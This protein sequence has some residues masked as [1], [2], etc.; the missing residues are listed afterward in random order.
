MVKKNI[1]MIAG[2]F[3]ER[4]GKY[5]LGLNQDWATELDCALRTVMD[6]KDKYKDKVSVDLIA[7]D[8]FYKNSHC[9]SQIRICRYVHEVIDRVNTLTYENKYDLILDFSVMP[10]FS[11]KGFKLDG[12]DNKCM[13]DTFT[14]DY[15][16]TVIGL[17]NQ[18]YLFSAVSYPVKKVRFDNGLRKYDSNYDVV[19]TNEIMSFDVNPEAEEFY[20][21]KNETFVDIST[22]DLLEDVLGLF[23]R[24]TKC[25]EEPFDIPCVEF[26]SDCKN[27]DNVTHS[28]KTGN[29]TAISDNSLGDRYIKAVLDQNDSND[30]YSR[31]VIAFTDKIDE[32]D[33][34]LH[35]MHI[36]TGRREILRTKNKASFMLGVPSKIVSNEEEILDFTSGELNIVQSLKSLWN[37]NGTKRISESTLY[38]FDNTALDSKETLEAVYDG[39][40][41]FKITT[42]RLAVGAMTLDV[43]CDENSTPSE[44]EFSVEV[45]EQ[46]YHVIE[47]IL[48][49]FSDITVVAKQ[50]QLAD[51]LIEKYGFERREDGAA[52]REMA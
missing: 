26:K 8:K 52:T 28:I 42:G 3:K 41:E 14:S 18:P 32:L 40:N 17:G 38:S 48:K 35:N 11:I 4:F 12:S 16:N 15:S 51:F 27:Y 13:G 19:V 21:T 7:D 10:K 23:D 9:D 2:V 20:I 24:K 31:Y 6:I 37:L 46:G 43:V 34:L 44:V 30:E 39:N 1:L 33:P 47:A 45:H 36:K 5:N 25:I 49:T 29:I 50:E 22:S